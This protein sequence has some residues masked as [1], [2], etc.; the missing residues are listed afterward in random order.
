M[1][2]LLLGMT[3]KSDVPRIEGKGK[4]I[5]NVD[6]NDSNEDGLHSPTK[7]K[8]RKDKALDKPISPFQLTQEGQHPGNGSTSRRH[9]P[10]R[11]GIPDK[12]ALERVLYFLQRNDQGEFF[13]G[14]NNPNVVYDYYSLA[15]QPMNFTT[16]RAKLQA[17]MYTTMEHFKH[18]VCLV[19]ANAMNANPPDTRRHQVAKALSHY[20]RQI[21]EDLSAQK[22]EYFQPTC[23]ENLLGRKLQ[24]KTIGHARFRY[25]PRNTTPEVEKRDKYGSQND[26]PCLSRIPNAQSNIQLNKNVDHYRDSLLH[27]VEELGPNAQMVAAN[28]LETLNSMQVMTVETQT[29]NLLANFSGTQLSPQQAPTQPG[30]ANNAHKLSLA[31]SLSNKPL[32][33]PENR[34]VTA[35]ADS[36]DINENACKG[37]KPEGKDGW[38]AHAASLLGDFFINCGKNETNKGLDDKK[39]HLS[40]DVCSIPKDK[41]VS[42]NENVAFLQGP[43]QFGAGS[44]SKDISTS[45]SQVSAPMGQFF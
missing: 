30:C 26:K 10:S 41:M 15:R 19:L 17:G 43:V 13:A 44:T 32:T 8:G 29:P 21:I 40:T 2:E 12:H 23:Q 9:V 36:V 35:T 38:N 28:N 1:L 18:D 24:S 33:I 6:V 16:V 37:K 34:K 25:T 5:M 11:N 39:P 20:A 45:S 14:P 42:P 4:H 7:K 31:L 27:F 3:G 22:P